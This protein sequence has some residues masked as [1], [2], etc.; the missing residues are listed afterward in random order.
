MLG[1]GPSVL[2]SPAGR[3]QRIRAAAEH[4]IILLDD[5]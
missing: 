3:L 5:H 4:E 2:V 1:I